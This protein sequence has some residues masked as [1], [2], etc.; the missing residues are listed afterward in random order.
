MA[1]L[2]IIVIPMDIN[3]ETHFSNSIRKT[4]STGKIIFR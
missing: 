2:L 1:L 4:R 3:A